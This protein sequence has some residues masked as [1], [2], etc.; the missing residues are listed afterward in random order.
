M[1]G[2]IED[3]VKERYRVVCSRASEWVVKGLG[4]ED[5]VVGVASRRGG[6]TLGRG[7]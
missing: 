6:S 3:G 1:N 5:D 4:K 7:I 2:R